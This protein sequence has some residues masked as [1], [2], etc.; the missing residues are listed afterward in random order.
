MIVAIEGCIGAGKSTTVGLLAD[1]LGWHPVYGVVPSSSFLEDFYEAPKRT[2]F[3]TELGFIV[4]HYHQLRWLEQGRDYIADLSFGRDMV[5][6][7]A[8]LE[9]EE[10]DIFDNLYVKLRERLE[11]PTLTI[12]LR[13]PTDELMRRIRARGRPYE[14]RMTFD[15]LHKI[16]EAYD[17]YAAELGPSV[18]PVDVQ[19]ETAPEAIAEK[20]LA[21]IRTEIPRAQ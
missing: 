14:A 11:Q 18:F 8:N 2:A 20:V 21:I 10:L 5:F 19:P 15:Y 3:E 17:E 9:G 13:L 1:T 6:A 16:N 12:L 7:R 4:L